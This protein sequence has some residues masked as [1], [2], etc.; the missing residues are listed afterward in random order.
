M[1]VGRSVG[2]MW[3]IIISTAAFHGNA[4]HGFDGAARSCALYLRALVVLCVDCISMVGWFRNDDD[5]LV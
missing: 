2:Q 3:W 1:V 5:E 4:I